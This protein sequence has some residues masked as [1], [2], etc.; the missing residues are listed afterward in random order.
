MWQF[1]EVECPERL[2]AVLCNS[3][4]AHNDSRVED[5][6]MCS[7]LLYKAYI[8][9]RAKPASPPRATPRN[10]AVGRQIHKVY[11]LKVAS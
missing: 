7:Q 8:L 5:P 9:V 3:K 11:F 10:P 2:K 6:R 4:S 1:I